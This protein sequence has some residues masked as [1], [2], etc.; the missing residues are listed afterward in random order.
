ADF[1]R[2]R[3]MVSVITRRPVLGAIEAL[4]EVRRALRQTPRERPLPEELVH[5][6]GSSFLRFA[7]LPAIRSLARSR[8]FPRMARHSGPC[9]LRRFRVAY[10][11]DEA[12]GAYFPDTLEMLESLG[13]ELVE[14]S[15]IRDEALPESVDLVMIGCGFPD[16]HADALAG[17]LSLIGALRSHV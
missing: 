3:T 14:F 5:R 7:D 12:F 16:Q 10:A 6:L 15:P 2:I 9:G 17:N 11:Q 8:P 4:P 13:A 1:E